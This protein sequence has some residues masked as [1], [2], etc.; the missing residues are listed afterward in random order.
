MY[1]LIWDSNLSIL[2]VP[3]EGYP[4]NASWALYLISTFLLKES[5][6]KFVLSCIHTETLTE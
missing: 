2:S 5:R 1:A 4:R 6:F 3:D